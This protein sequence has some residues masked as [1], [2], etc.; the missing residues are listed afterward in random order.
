MK[1][2]T[3][4]FF[5]AFDIDKQEKMHIGHLTTICYDLG[6]ETVPIF[7]N[8]ALPLTA[9][10]MV[11]L[12]DGKSMLNKDT[13]REGLVIRSMDN[14]ISFKAISNKFLLKNEE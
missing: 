11:S 6:L 10:E 2:Q 13:D 8:F 7:S 5:N 12:A 14:S 1:G 9:E 4:R 3:V